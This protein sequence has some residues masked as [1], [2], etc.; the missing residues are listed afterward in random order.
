MKASPT[1]AQHSDLIRQIKNQLPAAD[2]TYSASHI[3]TL[4]VPYDI[5][6]DAELRQIFVLCCQILAES[7]Q[8]SDQLGKLNQQLLDLVNRLPLTD[9]YQTLY[10]KTASYQSAYQQIKQLYIQFADTDFQNFCHQLIDAIT[11]DEL[12]VCDTLVEHLLDWAIAYTSG[13]NSTTISPRQAEKL[14]RTVVPNL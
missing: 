1:I 14:L 11:F 8:D 10:S 4:L 6:H 13:D 7:V 3:L 9:D 12:N 2:I 5:S